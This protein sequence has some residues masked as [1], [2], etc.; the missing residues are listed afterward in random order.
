MPPQTKMAILTPFSDPI[1]PK[2]FDFSQKPIGMPLI[3]FWGSKQP[4]M[5][6]Q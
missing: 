5:G 3:P 2:K 6:F 1:E 4:K